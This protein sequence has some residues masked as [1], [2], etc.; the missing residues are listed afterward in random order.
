MYP[1]DMTAIP[2]F[3]FAKRL[4]NLFF[5]PPLAWLPKVQSHDTRS[6]LSR[7]WSKYSF[8]SHIRPQAPWR[9]FGDERAVAQGPLDRHAENAR[10]AWQSCRSQLSFLNRALVSGRWDHFPAW[11]SSVARWVSAAAELSDM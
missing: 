7:K 8:R 5:G 1:Q 3:L 6:Q 4:P 2:R 9:N 10:T 11:P